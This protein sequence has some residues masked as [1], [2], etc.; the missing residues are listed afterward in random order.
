MTKPGILRP[1]QELEYYSH[2]SRARFFTC[3]ALG[4]SR[5]FSM[6]QGC[7]KYDCYTSERA[8][9]WQHPRSHRDIFSPQIRTQE[10]LGIQFHFAP[11]QGL[12]ETHTIQSVPLGDDSYIF[13]KKSAGK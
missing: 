9:N 11:E 8:A 2:R 5:N 7:E 10:R 4:E 12:V 3:E 13:S 1:P 6:D